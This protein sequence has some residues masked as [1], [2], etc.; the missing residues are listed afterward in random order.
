MSF[1]LLTMGCLSK[2]S[3]PDQTPSC[4]VA[5]PP[6]DRGLFSEASRW[7]LAQSDRVRGAE[8]VRAL[9]SGVWADKLRGKTRG[10]AIMV[11]VRGRRVC[12]PRALGSEQAMCQP[13]FRAV[14]GGRGRR[15]LPVGLTSQEQGY[16]EESDL[17]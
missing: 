3:A 16:V 5:N 10:S 4:P 12:A 13:V 15:R 9:W 14:S 11:C 6:P 7:G 17:F 2:T 8:R 1:H